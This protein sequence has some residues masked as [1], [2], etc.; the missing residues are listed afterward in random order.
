MKNIRYL[1]KQ[2]SSIVAVI[3]PAIATPLSRKYSTLGWCTI[4]KPIANCA[5]LNNRSSETYV[6]KHNYDVVKVVPVLK[7][8][9]EIRT[10]LRLLNGWKT[11]SLHK[12]LC[13]KLICYRFQLCLNLH[14][15]TSQ[16]HKYKFCS[17]SDACRC[18]RTRSTFK[19]NTISN[20]SLKWIQFLCG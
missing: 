6:H 16:W 5:N 17:C 1:C 15:W 13:Q 3:H 19:Y 20:I 7:H 8:Y 9:N 4:E 11:N 10:I 14:I 18:T 12:I 2:K